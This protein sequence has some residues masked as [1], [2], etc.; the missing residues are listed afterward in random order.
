MATIISD[1]DFITIRTRVLKE[2]CNFKAKVVPYIV[3]DG[4]RYFLLAQERSAV[5]QNS[6]LERFSLLGGKCDDGETVLDT[7]VRELGEE[8]MNIFSN[9]RKSIENIPRKNIVYF[10]KKHGNRNK[11]SIYVFFLP[12]KS[13]LFNYIIPEFERR[14]QILSKVYNDKPLSHEDYRE[15]ESFLYFKS[16]GKKINKKNVKCFN[17]IH[18]LQWFSEDEIINDPRVHAVL[19]SKFYHFT[20]SQTNKI[21]FFSEY[22]KELKN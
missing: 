15:L 6:K 1:R 9:T 13:Y 16:S 17:E 2:P 5:K 14:K 18:K 22:N 10:E 3:N 4:K 12:V 11:A 20:D 7:A 19:R 8:T 21:S